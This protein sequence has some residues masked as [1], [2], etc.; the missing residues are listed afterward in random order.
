MRKK[1][2]HTGKLTGDSLFNELAQIIEDSQRQLV[3]A[4]I[5]TLTMLFWQVGQRINQNILQNRRAE[6]GKQIVSTLSTQLKN[7]YGKNFELRNV[8]R[9]MQ[10]AEQ[11]TDIEI[12]VPLSRQLSWSH[13]VQL[14]PLKNWEA[15]LFSSTL[16][17]SFKKADRK[18]F[19]LEQIPMK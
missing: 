19:L 5:S 12:V 7:K 3:S 4:A 1:I 9:M 2:I 10:F 11:F 8:Q 15:K 16:I 18:N 17:D 6:Y 14:L 13:F